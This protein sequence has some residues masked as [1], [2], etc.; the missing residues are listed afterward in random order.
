MSWCIVCLRNGKAGRSRTRVSQQYVVV[1]ADRQIV[2]VTAGF[3]MDSSS[4]IVVLVQ[5]GAAVPTWATRRMRYTAI[6]V[7]WGVFLRVQRTTVPPHTAVRRTRRAVHAGNLVGINAEASQCVRLMAG[8]VARLFPLGLL[9]SLA[10]GLLR[11]VEHLCGR[12][13]DSPQEKLV[14]V[15]GLEPVT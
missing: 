5:R 4:R 6:R 13:R 15:T 12:G 9:A 10:R 3:A 11:R 1:V 14:P 8:R 2:A 7:D